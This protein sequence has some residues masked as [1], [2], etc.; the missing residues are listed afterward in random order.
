[1]LPCEAT[2]ARIPPSTSYVSELDRSNSAKFVSQRSSPKMKM[3]F[4]WRC[5]RAVP[6]LDE[7]EHKM[8]MELYSEGIRGVQRFRQT[9]QV[10]VS[11]VSVD[12][13]FRPLLDWFEATT[14]FRETNPAAIHHHRLAAFGP[15]C[16][17]CGH[18]LRTSQARFCAAC[19]EVVELED[20]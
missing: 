1:M 4:C 5:G 17:K 11:E 13:Y 7:A 2:L 19:G 6:M 8:A 16:K 15:S 18:L 9:S 12:D 10:P 20:I 14:G 3:V